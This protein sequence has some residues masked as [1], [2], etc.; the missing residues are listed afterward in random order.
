M[1]ESASSSDS[2]SIS[3]HSFSVD[4]T[5]REGASSDH[6]FPSTDLVVQEKESFQLLARGRSSKSRSFVTTAQTELSDRYE[7]REDVAQI[8]DDTWSESGRKSPLID[9]GRNHKFYQTTWALPSG[10][11]PSM[12]SPDCS[13]R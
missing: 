13:E 12:V 6:S 1:D 4:M 8:D 5:A 2:G 11:K 9:S 7:C 10:S 3:N